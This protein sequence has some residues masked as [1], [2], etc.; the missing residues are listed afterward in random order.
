MDRKRHYIKRVY[1]IPESE[2]YGETAIYINEELPKRG[3]KFEWVEK[4]RVDEE[5]YNCAYHSL[6][7]HIGN[8]K[9]IGTDDLIKWLEMI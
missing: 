3:Y 9:R 2:L 7:T 1:I 6:I 5:P 8:K 4:Y